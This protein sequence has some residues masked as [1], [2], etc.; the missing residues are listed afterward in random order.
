MHT[1]RMPT[2]QPPSVL[3][4][5]FG[6][7]PPERGRRMQGPPYPPPARFVR[8]ARPPVQPTP[9]SHVRW[10]W[11]R[12]NDQLRRVEHT[13]DLAGLVG[14]GT[15]RD[16]ALAARDGEDGVVALWPALCSPEHAAYWVSRAQ[17][18][19]ASERALGSQ[20]YRGGVDEQVDVLVDGG[21]RARLAEHDVEVAG[22]EH[23]PPPAA[24][25]VSEPLPR[26]SEAF[27]AEHARI[28]LEDLLA[29]VECE[30]TQ[31]AF[32][33]IWAVLHDSLELDVPVRALPAVRTSHPA[34]HPID[35]AAGETGIPGH[36]VEHVHALGGLA[37]GDA[38]LAR[39]LHAEAGEEGRV[40]E[41]VPHPEQPADS[42]PHSVSPRT[43][44][45]SSTRGHA[46]PRRFSTGSVDCSR[47]N[48]TCSAEWN[49][50]GVEVDLGAERADGQQT[51]VAHDEQRGHGLVEEPWV[52]VGR[53]L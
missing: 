3:N 13:T 45:T 16:E 15:D 23:L 49:E 43:P 19:R 21:R 4:F 34:D 22:L 9:E 31:F 52:D 33:E 14:A 37:V 8:P 42:R 44:T 48:S 11:T 18:W 38:R 41:L 35:Q 51:R 10:R 40:G 6:S 20:A 7:G 39:E 24:A 26:T 50:P 47:R 32:D 1:E 5:T 28:V 30:A 46:S 2:F 27:N 36:Q 25:G 12:L 53:L 17:R 29:G